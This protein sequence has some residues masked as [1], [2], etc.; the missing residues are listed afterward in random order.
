[1]GFPPILTR[2]RAIADHSSSAANS[3]RLQLKIRGCCAAGGNFQSEFAALA[4]FG[5]DENFG[6]RTFGEIDVRGGSLALGGNLDAVLADERAGLLA[7]D[8]QQRE[9]AAGIGDGVRAAAGVD[10]AGSGD[11]LEADMDAGQRFSVESDAA[12]YGGDLGGG[13]AGGRGADDDRS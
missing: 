10:V 5:G 11:W 3:L 2:R 1:M 13:A 12:R 7:L 6:R 4:V 8:Q 9:L